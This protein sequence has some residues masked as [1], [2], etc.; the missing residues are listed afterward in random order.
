[1][2]FHRSSMRSGPLRRNDLTV[3]CRSINEGT[4]QT[5]EWGPPNGDL[6][7]RREDD[8]RVEHPSLDKP[9]HQLFDT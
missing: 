7:H 4:R 8:R 1:M 3:G 9:N 6:G 2:D 5:G